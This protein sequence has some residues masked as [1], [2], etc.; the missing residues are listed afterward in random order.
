M[1]DTVHVVNQD[2]FW[3]KSTGLAIVTLFFR[4]K[5]WGPEVEGGKY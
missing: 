3:P 1:R 5:K 2:L 4:E